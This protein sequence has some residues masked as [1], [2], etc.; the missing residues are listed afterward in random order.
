MKERFNV[1]IAG[2]T[3]SVV[4]DDGEKLVREAEA[5]LNTDVAAVLKQMGRFSKL[6]AVTLCALD[7]CAQAQKA[8][9]KIKNLEAQIEILEANMHRLRGE[10]ETTAAPAKK[11]ASAKT[12]EASPAPAAKAPEAEA[13]Q[14]AAQLAPAPEKAPETAAKT[15]TESDDASRSRKF[16][17]LEE[18]LG[19]QLKFEIDQ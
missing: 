12:A 3:F 1:E 11:T 5:T 17:Q 2:I 13:A 4:T 8:E 9:A 19:S 7:Y 10:E 16:R 6:D 14:S 15:K 18:L